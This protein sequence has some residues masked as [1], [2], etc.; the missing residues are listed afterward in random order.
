M[1]RMQICLLVIAACGGQVRIERDDAGEAGE[2]VCELEE[3]SCYAGPEAT[4]GV[5][6]CRAGLQHCEADGTGYGACLGEVLPGAEICATTADESCDGE[7]R[8]TGEVVWTDDGGTAGSHGG[9]AVAVDSQGNV[10]LTGRLIGGLAIGGDALN[11]DDYAAFVMK[12]DEKGVVLWSHVAGAATVGQSSAG[13]AITTDSAGNVFVAGGFHGELEIAGAS[14]SSKGAS[15][16]FVIALTPDGSLRYS[17][18]LGGSQSDWIDDIA[19]SESGALSLLGGFEGSTDVGGGTKSAAGKS[20]IFLTQLDESGEPRWSHTFGSAGYDYALGAAVGPGGEIAIG[21][22][23]D[24]A[25]NLGGGPL[26][27]ADEDAFVALFT[28]AGEHKWSRR[29]GGKGHELVKG[30]TIDPTGEVICAGLFTSMTFAGETLEAEGAF[31]A[32]VARFDPQ[33]TPKKLTR[34]GGP[35]GTASFT[36]IASDAAGNV[37]AFGLLTGTITLDG[38]SVTAAG[39]SSPSGPEDL[40]VVK[41]EPTHSHAWSHTFG[42]PARERAYG[43][44]V[45]PSGASLLTGDFQSTIDFGAGALTAPPESGWGLYLAKLAP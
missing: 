44:A 11:A 14:M 2:E 13:R 23:F 45:A 1:K 24:G 41:L 42:G 33:G 15:D 22:S 31:D 38:Q 10:L 18:R 36:R 30:V 25:L 34:F 27:S 4:L 17:R 21:G 19:I 43:L 16:V 8:C 7:G 12:L 28:E 37:V 20:D 39:A 32:F 9:A 5:G 40:L 3:R 29:L 35:Q 26:E 6:A